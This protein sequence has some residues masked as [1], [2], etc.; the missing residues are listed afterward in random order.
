MALRD[1]LVALASF[2]S[3][4]A[5][6]TTISTDNFQAVLAA[7]SQVLRSLKPASLDSFD[8]S[9]DDVFSSRN[10]DGNYHTGDITFRYRS[11]TSG[12]WQT[13]DSA[14]ERAPVTS[15]SGGL[16]SASLG[17]T[18]AD[19]AA[20]LNV[21]RRW[22]D[23]DGDIGLEFTLTNVAAESVEIGS[24]GMP[25]EFNN[26]FTDRTAVETRDNCVLLDPYIG[27]HAGYVQATRLTGTGPNL[28]V[29]PLNA[30][31]KFEAWRFLP[32]DSTEPLYYQS[33][34][35]EGNYEWQVY[36]KAWAENEWS[37][38]DPWNEPTSATLEPGANITV[39]LRFSVAAS[40]PEIEDTVVASGTPLAVGIPGYILPTDVTGRLFLH[41]NDTVDSISS[42]P[43]DAFTFS[44]P[45][46][47]SAGVVEY[48]LTPSASA[49][50]R[51]RL[52]IQYASG[53]T[54]TV[55]YRLTKPAP[56]AV[57]DLGA[58]LTTEQW[59]DDTSDPF[60]RGHSIITYDHDAAAL[61][62]QDNRAWI[63]G[64]SDEGGAGA[65]LAAALKQSAAPSAA[66]VAKLE[67]FVADVVWGT[68]QVST[69]GADD[70][71]AVRKSVFYYEPDAVPANY[72]YD[73]AIGWDTWSAWD[74]AAAYATDRAY[75]YVHVAGLYWGLYRAGRAAP[76]VLTRNL[77][78]NDYLLRAQK[79]VASMMRT[80]AAGEHETGYWDLGLM[81]ET[82]FGHVLEDLRA[83]GLTEQA[84]ELEADMRTRAELWKGQED[85]F[86]S[87]MAWDSTGQEGVYY[88]A[89]YFND[90]ATASK[91]ISSITGYMPTV[92]HWGWNGNA[93]RYWDFIYGGKLQRLERQIH[94]YGSGLNALPLLAAYRSDPSSDAASAYYRLRVGHAGSQAALAS[95][96][97]DGFA[98]AAFH[99][100]PDT[101]AWDAY[102]GD[103][104]PNFLGHALAATTYLAAEHAVYG[105]TAFGGNVV[106]DDAADVVVTVSPKDSARRNVYVA[107]LGVYV[108]LDA[109]VV[110][111][112][113]Y[114]PGTKGLVVRVKGDP[115]YGAEVASSAVVT[116]EQSAVVE[117]VG[118]VRVVTEGLE[119]AKGGWV[120]DLSDGEV[121]E[122]AFG[123]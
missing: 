36:T 35:Y 61:V 58:F 70:Q 77:T 96:H 97:A 64:L 31:T 114:T 18:L 91:A 5:A 81:G 79:T 50:G 101:L 15:S 73:P 66:E 43:A 8:F 111:G 118:E 11:G 39:G 72:T 41:T 90:T 83:E 74:R 119:R 71:Y 52:T 78:A 20:T 2:F 45:S 123:V 116:V 88:W 44:D 89:K 112:F 4:V 100:W 13:G 76:A 93:R 54:Q 6:Q 106:V 55:H 17:P 108:R 26:I 122:V 42:T 33:Q 95:I 10:G 94:H 69:D 34:T 30:D 120:V 51:V 65:W 57:A 56:E 82:V 98:A 87:E 9:P 117:G 59:F 107:P 16:A 105:W 115:G 68:L 60:G 27:L 25:V 86:G 63:A 84:D 37:G 62:L 38:V 21:T 110:D 75:D 113:A 3:I 85:P 7:D 29:T 49:W 104:G 23:V 53:K 48:Q 28:V 109:G 80:D 1:G 47:R 24:L 99:S 32:E 102:S 103:Y 19:A 12:S 40:A 92:A 67:T 22:I 121:H 14:A 46:T